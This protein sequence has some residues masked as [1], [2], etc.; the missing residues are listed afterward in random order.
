MRITIF[1]SGYVGLVTGAC[2]A[3]AGTHVLCVDVDAGKIE[4]TIHL[5]ALG[6]PDPEGAIASIVTRGLGLKLALLYNAPHAGELVVLDSIDALGDLRKAVVKRDGTDYVTTV[7]AGDGE[8]SI[9]TA[10]VSRSFAPGTPLHAAAD[11]LAESLG[12]GVG[13]ARDA[14]AS[15]A[16]ATGANV[17]AEGATLTGNA[18]SE[19]TQLCNAA[20]LTWSVQDGNLQLLPLGGALER[21][22]I[23]LSED[24]GMVGAPEIVNRRTI[25]VTALL[26]PGLVPGQQVVVRSSVESARGTPALSAGAWRI[27]EA[28]YAGDTNGGE[29]Y[30]KLTCHRPLPPLVG[31]P[32]GGAV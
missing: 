13:N 1:G 21:T 20:R 10:R 27:T 16:F 12:V 24:T 23:L 26:Q 19:L 25:T 17:F 2:L 31:P 32:N 29:W 15:A 9:R 8:H 5:D 30:A 14:F 22:A 3:D 4:S 7:T 6:I 18:A 28:E 11:A